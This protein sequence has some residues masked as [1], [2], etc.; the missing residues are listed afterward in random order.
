MAITVCVF[1]GSRPGNNPDWAL[2]SR[3]LGCE[4]AN[5]GWRLVFGGGSRGLM[6][7]LARGALSCKGKVIGVIPSFLTEAEPVIENLEELH[8]VQS[9]VA[10]KEMM[11]KL[12]NVFMVLPGGIGTF[13]ELFEVWTGN[14]IH[15]YTKSIVIINLDG[16]YDGL[17]NYAHTV[18]AQGFLTDKHFSHITLVNSVPEAIAILKNLDQA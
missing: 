15:A 14:H 1:C 9:M 4:I 17:I 2:A 13:E 18:F 3:Q 8:V 6:G 5:H 7:E 11:I 16:F 10:R 12:S